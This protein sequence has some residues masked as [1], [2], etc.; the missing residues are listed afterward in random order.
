MT[1]L[2]LF[3]HI[4]RTGGTTLRDILERQYSSK[5]TVEIKKFINTENDLNL[6]SR[7]RL[8]NLSLIK[9][10]LPFGTHNWVNRPCK[11]FTFLRHP[12]A[13]TISTYNYAKKTKSHRDNIFVQSH[14]LAEYLDSK[15]NIMLNNGMTR[16]LAGHKYVFNVPYGK[17][18]E[19]HFRIAKDNLSKYFIV[20]GITERF[21]ESVLALSQLLNWKKPYYSIANKTI[22]S[23]SNFEKDA[24]LIQIH[25]HFDFQLYDYANTLLD[26]T[27]SIIPNFQSILFQF[28]N[29]NSLVGKFFINTRIK[30][31]FFRLKKTLYT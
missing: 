19:E 12:V 4:P 21:N 30:R 11:Y 15:K 17:I 6:I 28:E 20:A 25:N 8:L 29:N 24:E 2:I 26:E 3:L 10:H 9:G 13:R 31:L 16:L 14:S 18:N 1:N 22:K 23:N 27:I 5:K 7:E